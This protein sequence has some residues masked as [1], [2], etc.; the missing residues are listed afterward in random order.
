MKILIAD[1]LI[2]IYAVIQKGC[3][4]V[5]NDRK[6]PVSAIHRLLKNLNQNGNKP[7]AQ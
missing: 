6:D 3:H 2:L 4:I 1:G 5:S 7:A